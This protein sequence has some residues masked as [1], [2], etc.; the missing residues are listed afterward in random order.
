[1]RRISLGRQSGGGARPTLDIKT[2]Y[3]I[4]RRFSAYLDVVNVLMNPDRET[5]FGFDRPQTTHLMR[6]Q[7]YFGLNARL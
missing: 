7:F 6:P 1:V 5:Q 2:L 3:N 4:N